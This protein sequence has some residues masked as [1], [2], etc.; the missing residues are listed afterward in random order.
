MSQFWVALILVLLTGPSH[1]AVYNNATCSQRG[2]G[3]V[4][5]EG[6]LRS[7]H[8]LASVS[9]IMTSLWALE[10]LGVDYRFSTVLHMSRSSSGGLRVHIEGS[11]NPL[12]GRNLSYFLI[13]ELNRMD[14]QR[15]DSLTFDE[16]L[17]LAWQVEESPYIGG[18]TPRYRTIQE[19]VLAV[20]RELQTYFAT[21]I[22]QFHYDRLRS[23]AAD[24]QV[25]LLSSPR[26]SIRS[27]DFLAKSRFQ[28]VRGTVSISLK[29]SPLITLLKRMNN[30][31]N[32]YVADHL[33]WNLGGTGS[34]AAHAS[35][36]WGLDQN[37]LRFVNGS[38]NNEGSTESPLYNVGTCDAVL[39]VLKLSE[40]HLAQK[41][42]SLTSILPVADKDQDSTLSGF[43]GLAAGAMTAKTGTVNKA[44]TLAG[45]I[46]SQEGPVMFA[47][48]LHMDQDRDSSDSGVANQMIKNKVGQLFNTNRG[49]RL[50]NY[51]ELITLPFDQSS[52]LTE[53]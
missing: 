27:I 22:N 40:R 6:D 10:K 47:I 8:P 46:S 48:L 45:Q 42:L 7:R 3:P 16:N 28:K 41:G 20:N 33:F 21:S 32:N 2:S 19:Q 5:G 31:S 50:L 1:A 13:S 36:F 23:Q 26:I 49:P 44:K 9:K 35:S 18:V 34:F 29:S 24:A 52:Y 12:F 53:L 4:M 25:Y 37:Q 17:L 30:Q 15:I 11:R 51:T 39:K 43:G 38:G 14:V